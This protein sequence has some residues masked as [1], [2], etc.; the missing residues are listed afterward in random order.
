MRKFSDTAW[1]IASRYSEV[2]ASETRDLAA[3]ID[4]AI[5]G[6]KSV[7]EGMTCYEQ[8]EIQCRNR[9]CFVHGCVRKTGRINMATEL[10]D[11][12]VSQRK[13]FEEGGFAIARND[14]AIRAHVAKLSEWEKMVRDLAK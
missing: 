12:L 3:A 14:P 5:E 1:E 10:A 6:K 7:A 13:N 4:A 11:W 9:M 2:L 8:D